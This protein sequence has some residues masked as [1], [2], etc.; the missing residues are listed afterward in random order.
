MSKRLLCGAMLALLML[1]PALAGAATYAEGQ[2]WE[3]KTRPDEKGSLLKIN[4]IEYR[5]KIGTV[6]HLSIIGLKIKAPNAEGPTQPVLQHLPVSQVTLD[7]SVTRLSKKKAKFPDY[8]RGY[9]EWKKAFEG[10]QAGV[11]SQP[12]DEIIA[13]VEQT[14]SAR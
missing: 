6:Y 7:Q 10:G 4:K 9:G 5:L 14:Y 8:K 13:S 3:Y 2:V 12:V 11:F 1:I